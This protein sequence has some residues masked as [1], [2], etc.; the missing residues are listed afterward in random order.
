[1][2]ELRLRESWPLAWSHSLIKMRQAPPPDG[3]DMKALPLAL[4]FTWAWMFH[5]YIRRNPDHTPTKSLKT[6]NE[7]E[8]TVGQWRPWWW[9]AQSGQLNYNR[10]PCLEG[11][12]EFINS[13]PF[14]H[15]S[16]F[17]FYWLTWRNQGTFTISEDFLSKDRACHWS[18]TPRNLEL[19]ISL[20]VP[21]WLWKY[22]S[23]SVPTGKINSPKPPVYHVLGPLL[24]EFN[25]NTWTMIL[26]PH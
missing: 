11:T 16:N 10:V 15:W 17:H 21:L 19:I 1:M 13:S 18:F 14:H 23:I 6:T 2:K 4:Y 22:W 9:N 12:T 26:L 24:R 8:T 20:H 7:W 3:P 25:I 5:G